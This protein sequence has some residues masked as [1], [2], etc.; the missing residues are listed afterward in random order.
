MIWP[1]KT[2]DVEKTAIIKNINIEIVV[3]CNLWK[4][5]LQHKFS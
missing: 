1:I 3:A 2:D 4:I 5:H